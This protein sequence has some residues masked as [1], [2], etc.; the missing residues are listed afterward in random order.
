MAQ[1][2]YQMPQGQRSNINSKLLKR[3]LGLVLDEKKLTVEDNGNVRYDFSSDQHMADPANNVAARLGVIWNGS[4]TNVQAALDE[5]LGQILTI[6]GSGSN[7]LDIGT[8]SFAAGEAKAFSVDGTIPGSV[9]NEG[10]SSMYH[11]VIEDSVS[12]LKLA[13]GVIMVTS[14][15][16]G[17]EP[18]YVFNWAYENASQDYGPL[19]WGFESDNEGLATFSFWLKRR[20]SATPVDVRIRIGLM[21]AT[22][23]NIGFTSLV[24]RSQN[25]PTAIPLLDPTGSGSTLWQNLS[26]DSPLE[27]INSAVGVRT[28][29]TYHDP[30]TQTELDNLLN[31]NDA[32][33]IWRS[34]SSFLDLNLASSSIIVPK[35]FRGDAIEIEFAGAEV[36]DIGAPIYF[37]GEGYPGTIQ[38]KAS[39][40][41]T[42]PGG[43]LTNIQ[44]D[45]SPIY[46]RTLELECDINVTGISSLYYER[47]IDNGFSLTGMVEQTSW[48]NTS[49]IVTKSDKSIWSNTTNTGAIAGLELQFENA[50]QVRFTQ[51]L[52]HS[53]TSGDP[54]LES[55]VRLDTDLIHTVNNLGVFA[56]LI[57]FYLDGGGNVLEFPSPDPSRKYQGLI[58]LGAA[59]V[60]PTDVIDVVPIANLATSPGHHLQDLYRYI[61]IMRQ[62]VTITPNDPLNLQ[63][64][65]SS[66]FLFSLF[67][68]HYVNPLLPND[69]AIGAQSSLSF[70]PTT[71]TDISQP[72]TQ[73]LDPDQ[74]FDP[75]LSSLQPVPTN[76]WTFQQVFIGADD[77]YFV[78][79]GNAVYGTRNQALEAFSEGLVPF[80]PH[81]I[82]TNRQNAHL[83]CT[84][85]MQ[86]GAVNGGF[87]Y[88]VS[89]EPFGLGAGGGSV[90]VTPN[91]QEVTDNGNVTTNGATFGGVLT[92]QGDLNTNGYM[93]IN[94]LSGESRL[95]FFRNNVQN[96]FVRAR[97]TNTLTFTAYD[98]I[99]GAFLADVLELTPTGA[100]INGVNP[101]QTLSSVMTQGNTTSTSMY[102]TSSSGIFFGSVGNAMDIDGEGSGLYIR[103]RDKLGQEIIRFN[104][105]SLNGGDVDVFRKMNLI[106]ATDNGGSTTGKKMVVRDDL[107]NELQVADIPG[108]GGG[109]GFDSWQFGRFL[110]GFASS[111]L[112]IP[113]AG[114]YDENTTIAPGV[115]L[116]I[117]NAGTLIEV[118]MD[119]VTFGA[120]GVLDININGVLTTIGVVTSGTTEY[121]FTG[122][123]IAVAENDA[124]C[125]Q[126][127]LS[128]GGS[129]V[130]CAIAAVIERS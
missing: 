71:T 119:C 32:F 84:I 94:P 64:D 101:I 93:T 16:A 100:T 91:L 37:M 85:L 5:L 111:G 42:R 41:L 52:G 54:A 128:S 61:G 47:L 9:L 24:A 7:L 103:V 22:E 21:S 55:E 36:W 74:W 102:M 104:D 97:S 79:Y 118:T 30:Q 35:K 112:Q 87:D 129:M 28:Q 99:T 68:N 34:D 114:A 18:S 108:G 65:V 6:Q 12:N 40:R 113:P 90:T 33:E 49:E 127:T 83:L 89:P 56:P 59:V 130:G 70:T 48:D 120:T 116:R 4:A 107:T 80:E 69:V 20:G 92:A 58:S 25:V 63:L 106:N 73:D 126:L 51:G 81:P 125:F 96:W 72:L 117:P 66:G 109:A 82:L 45:G 43:T 62:G 27:P 31:R 110:N 19:G 2:L 60:T 23:L 122:L 50:T 77:G 13:Q 8:Y 29:L 14:N 123:A 88:F 38:P 1:I 86:E 105:S 11:L 39:L 98:E 115:F 15:T 78:T 44:L 75:L 53:M 10:E 57:Y 26:S 67:A 3:M 124:V 76:D 95:R 46:A 17:A 121:T